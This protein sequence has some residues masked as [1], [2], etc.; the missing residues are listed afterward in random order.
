MTEMFYVCIV[1]YSTR[2][3]L[4][5]GYHII[6]DSRDRRS[7]TYG[8]ESAEMAN[9]LDKIVREKCCSPQGS[10]HFFKVLLKLRLWNLT[11]GLYPTEPASM[12]RAEPT[13]PDSHPPLW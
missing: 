6:L 13:I 4:A 3:W 2:M 1:Q 5:S 11:H 10:P 7:S 12:A 8:S 9:H